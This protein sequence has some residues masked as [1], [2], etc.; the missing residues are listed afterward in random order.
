MCGRYTE[1]K[2]TADVK[3]RIAFDRAQMELLP[4][5]N[6]APT[7]PAP[8]VVVNG[9][10][11]VLKPMRWG[12]I[13]FW[14]KEQS[15]GNHLIN[16][17]AETVKEKPAF[18]ASFKRRRCLVVA[19]SFYEWQKLANSKLKQPMRILLQNEQPFAF[20]GLWD[21]W[22]APDGA[23]VETFTIITGE[24]NDV[25][26]SIHNRMAVILPPNH[27]RQW[28]DPTFQ[29]ADAL[30]RL[31]IPYP[32]AEIKAH[33]VSTRVNNPKFEDPQCV[34]PWAPGPENP[35]NWLQ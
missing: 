20:A 29:D 13:P 25:V 23:E 16:A 2:R 21:S 22:T 35:A 12:L 5:F 28:L 32:A 18:R 3:A 10:E 27:Y 31:L 8:V 4:R 15:I 26:A 24:P 7:Q 33:P 14:A 1:S 6:I 34:E 19:D 11:V 9:G 17:R 30:S